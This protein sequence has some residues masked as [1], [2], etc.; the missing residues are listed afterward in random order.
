MA[1]ARKVMLLGEM[2][3]GKPSLARRLVHGIFEEDY[4]ATIGVDLYTHAVHAAG[5]GRINLTLWDVDG[6]FG[7]SIMG[8]SYLRGSSGAVIVADATRPSTFEGM[9]HLARLFQETMPGRPIACAA[10]KLDL[11]ESMPAFELPPDFRSAGIPLHL[12]SAKRGT[13][14]EPLFTGLSARI[15]ERQL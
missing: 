9:L 3:V 13:G 8:H 5:G 10:S 7:D 14:I 4:K 15:L 2:G 12:T 6:D 1:V 11:T